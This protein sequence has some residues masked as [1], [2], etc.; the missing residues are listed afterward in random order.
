MLAHLINPVRAQLAGGKMDIELELVEESEEETRKQLREYLEGRRRSFDL[1]YTL[2]EGFTG[3]VLRLV[4]SIPYGCTQSY[5]E[6]AEKL[7]TAA[8]AVGQ[9]C[10]RNP[11]PVIVP[12][13]R[14]VSRNGTGG[15][16]AGEQVKR[17]LLQ[18]ESGR[19]QLR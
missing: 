6:V 10:G 19:L 11:L 17:R 14:V 1:D 2:P 3:E 4:D 9:A 15:Y 7:D 8:V 18:L 5:G 12:C 16:I 13:H